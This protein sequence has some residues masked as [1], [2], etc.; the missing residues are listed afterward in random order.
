MTNC[1][2]YCIPKMGVHIKLQMPFCQD[3]LE[4]RAKMF[5]AIQV[6]LHFFSHK[7]VE[8][9]FTLYIYYQYDIFT[10][11]IYQMKNLAFL[12]V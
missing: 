1:L 11:I 12:A 7:I 8:K 4:L 5:L 3:I 10:G 2:R 6:A 9:Q